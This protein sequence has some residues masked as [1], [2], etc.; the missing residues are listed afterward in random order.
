MRS[1]LGRESGLVD[2]VV[3]DGAAAWLST[4]WGGGR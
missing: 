4:E 3:R 1:Y 2:E